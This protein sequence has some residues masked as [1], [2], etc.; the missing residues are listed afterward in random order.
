[1]TIARPLPAIP[2]QFEDALSESSSFG[3]DSDFYCSP[4]AGI[5]T[6]IPRSTRALEDHPVYDAV[7]LTFSRQT[8]S[9]TASVHARPLSTILEE[10]EE[11]LSQNSWHDSESCLSCSPYNGI[12][13]KTLSSSFDTRRRYGVVE[14]ANSTE[15]LMVAIPEEVVTISPSPGLPSFSELTE[16]DRA[17]TGSSCD[18]GVQD[19][20]DDLSG[21]SL[22]DA[23]LAA[24]RD[25]P[26]IMRS[27]L[28][29]LRD[30]ELDFNARSFSEDSDSDSEYSDC[31]DQ[32]EADTDV[33][34]PVDSSSPDNSGRNSLESTSWT[35]EPDSEVSTEGSIYPP[36][37]PLKFTP[38]LTSAPNVD[39]TSQALAWHV[40]C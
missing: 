34:G 31:D 32:D 33:P 28:E 5:E 15:S 12:S 39:G 6:I 27:L 40:V 11:D 18:V 30:F 7:S 22:H 26:E 21:S 13:P 2:V 9:A 14:L 10:S 16:T 35:S 8:L 25:A 37:P 17:L 29:E 19:G 3:S 23:K 24:I 4:Y 36:T 1:M 20:D 38:S